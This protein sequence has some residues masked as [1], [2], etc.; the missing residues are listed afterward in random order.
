MRKLSPTQAE[1]C[2]PCFSSNHLPEKQTIWKGLGLS[3]WAAI[4]TES[5]LPTII[6]R[7]VFSAWQKT[8]INFCPGWKGERMA[9]P[10]AQY[11]C[12]Q[13]LGAAAMLWLARFQQE[14]VRPLHQ[15]ALVGEDEPWWNS[16]MPSR[17]R[18]QEG[19]CVAGAHQCASSQTF[20]TSVREF[21]NITLA[22]QRGRGSSIHAHVHA[23][24][25]IHVRVY[26]HDYDHP[27]PI[28]QSMPMPR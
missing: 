12:G 3:S 22:V 25:H 2:K 13:L 15:L 11:W 28:F 7:C 23:H 10:G 6:L 16:E 20:N 1:L 26:A 14:G 24:S 9:V 5:T 18:E 19:A 8:G 4:R 17:G 21:S 27:M